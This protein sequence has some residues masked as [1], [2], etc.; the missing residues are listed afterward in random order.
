[1]Q[2]FDIIFHRFFL[3]RYGQ[4][5]ALNSLDTQLLFGIYYVNLQP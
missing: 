5:V 3:I 4:L 1:M 2:I